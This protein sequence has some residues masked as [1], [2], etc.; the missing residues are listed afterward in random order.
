MSLSY[1]CFVMYFYI[2]SYVIVTV[3]LTEVLADV[4][5]YNSI[6]TAMRPL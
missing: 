3:I 2:T 1:V 6:N 4:A 5:F